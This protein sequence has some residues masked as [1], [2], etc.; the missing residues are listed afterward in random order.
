M[1]STHGAYV[2]FGDS[3]YFHFLNTYL[4]VNIF[5]HS[6]ICFKLMKRGVIEISQFPN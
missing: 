2:V 4:F 5:I 1:F 6:F 3:L